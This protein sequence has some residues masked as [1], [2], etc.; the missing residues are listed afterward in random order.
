MC[1]IVK[2]SKL[3]SQSELK[4]QIW[5]FL[6]VS[7]TGFVKE[8]IPA[9]SEILNAV[10]TGKIEVQVGLAEYRS[11]AV[12]QYWTAVAFC[13]MSGACLL[14]VNLICMQ[15]VSSSYRYH[16]SVENAKCSEQA[17]PAGSL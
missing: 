13:C 9:A 4:N 10:W 15:V 8:K 7:V 6:L 11:S 12:S 5:P 16:G 17:V 1:C 3:G 14:A 2:E